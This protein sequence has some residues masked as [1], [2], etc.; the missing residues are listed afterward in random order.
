MTIKVTFSK[1]DEVL[2][3]VIRALAAKSA[4]NQ[5]VSGMTD[6]YLRKNGCYIFE[7]IN[8]TQ[9][10]RFKKFLVEYIPDRF[11][12]LLKLTEA[13]NLEENLE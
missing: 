9:V 1:P 7:F 12:G 8:S 10:S 5:I 3:S 6:A 4:G 13:S 2:A 11:Q